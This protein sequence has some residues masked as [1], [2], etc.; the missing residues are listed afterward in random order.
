VKIQDGNR[1]NEQMNNKPREEENRT[2]QHCKQTQ[3]KLEFG[4]QP[5]VL[6]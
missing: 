2:R 6:F 3:N 1:K 4:K 5:G